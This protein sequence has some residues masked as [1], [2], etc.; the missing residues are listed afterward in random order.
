MSWNELREVKI[1]NWG[2]SIVKNI[3]EKKGWIVY[4][5]ITS[6]PHAFDFITT[7]DKK[8]VVICEVKTKPRMLK[9]KATGI[10]V[11][12]LNEYRN[13]RNEINVEFYLFFV[14][15]H[16]DQKNVYYKELK[17]LL[18][19]REVDGV[20]YPNYDICK[21]IVL[22]SLD[23]MHEVGKLTIDQLKEYKELTRQLNGPK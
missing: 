6:G 12:H 2:E 11:R 20:T 15:A 10:D 13:I 7:K 22:F 8:K 16:P 19:K 14:D 5:P 1:G 18:K 3:I 9:Y 21:G 23:D 17:T 4:T